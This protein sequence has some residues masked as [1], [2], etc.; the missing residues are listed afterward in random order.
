MRFKLHKCIRDDQDTVSIHNLLFSLSM[1]ASTHN[2]R[3]RYVSFL[4][5]YTQ[6]LHATIIYTSR[7]AQLLLSKTHSAAIKPAAKA[8]T[9]TLI[10]RPGA[11]VGAASPLEVAVG[12]P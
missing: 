2:R 4:C 5:V 11:A 7:K 12:A 6:R 8:P 3:E 1:I 10:P 9:P